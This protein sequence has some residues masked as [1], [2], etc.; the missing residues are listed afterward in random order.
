MKRFGAARDFAEKLTVER[1][2]GKIF[3]SAAKKLLTPLGLEA[4][5]APG[6]GTGQSNSASRKIVFLHGDP[7]ETVNPP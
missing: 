2:S 4:R 3:T 6:G 5:Y 7:P 1:A